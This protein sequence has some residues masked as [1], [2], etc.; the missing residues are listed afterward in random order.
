MWALSRWNKDPTVE[1]TV[2]NAEILRKGRN[3]GRQ[4]A[5]R[6]MSVPTTVQ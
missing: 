1:K 3:M 5:I 2:L 4:Q 6:A